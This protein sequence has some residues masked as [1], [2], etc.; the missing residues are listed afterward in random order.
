MKIFLFI[1]PFIFVT[2]TYA[3]ISDF[4]HLDFKKSDSIALVY[5]NEGLYNLP[6]LA[7]QLTSTLDTDAERFRAIYRWVCN[8]IS[9]NYSLYLKHKRK[10]ERF[11]N[12]SLKLKNWNDDFRKKLFNKLL[13][14][15][16]TICTGYAYLVK[17]LA[18]LAH[19]DCEIVQGYGRVSTTDL[20]KLDQPNHSWN[21]V[22]LNNKWYLCDPTWASGIPDPKTNRFTFQYNDGFFLTNPKLFAVNHFPVEE[23]WWLLD[24]TIPSFKSFLASPVIYGNAY[25]YLNRHVL[26]KKMHHTI[27]PFD[28]ITFEYQVKP[29]VRIK[30]ITLQI[31]NGF[32]TWKTKPHATS[33]NKTSLIIEYQ[34]KTLGFYDVHFFIN[35]DLISTYTVKVK[36]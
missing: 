9:N 2:Q 29:S 34:F 11:K 24:K 3:Q 10:T 13:K 23:K 22:K 18:Q 25:T 27:I 14:D 5:K 20:E 1:L 32:N 21:A 16:S 35:D 4:D 8:N 26:P 7:F 31:D 36:S 28:K 30:D 17:E 12:D 15:Q 33:L 19:I 6:Q